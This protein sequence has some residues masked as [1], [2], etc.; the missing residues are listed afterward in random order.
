MMQSK[1]NGSIYLRVLNRK[2]IAAS[3]TALI[4][5]DLP[6]STKLTNPLSQAP[7]TSPDSTLSQV[8][9]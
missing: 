9:H 4:E 5:M 7:S 2:A 6:F 3:S 8:P 1:I